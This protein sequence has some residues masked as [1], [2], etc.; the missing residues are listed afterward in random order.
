MTD[1]RQAA[2]QALEALTI[3]S[4]AQCSLKGQAAITALRTALE[5]Q[6]EPVA[7][8]KEYAA[9]N[10]FYGS[11]VA[12]RSQLPFMRHIDDG[13]HILQLIGASA[14]AKAAFCLHP[15]VQNNETVDVSWSSAHQLACEYRDKANAY[16]CRPDTDYVTTPE[17]VRFLVGN[18]SDDCRSMLIADKRQNYGDFI[19]EHFGKHARSEQLD[20]YFRLWLS[21]LEGTPTPPQQQAETPPEWPLV[22]NIL[23]EY[24]LDAIAF[25]AEFKAAQRPWVGLT[26][27]EVLDL[28]DVNNVYGSKWVEFAR[29]VEAALR[30]KN[31]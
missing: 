12:L 20:R 10:A 9:I 1:L 8:A 28:F 25:V 31:T 13:L 4:D 19:A 14:L 15:I 11:R 2:Q 27:E 29:T 17:D 18:M 16:L 26:P 30:S 22:K 7:W 21:F 6:A 23:D 24:G 3:Y 5:Q